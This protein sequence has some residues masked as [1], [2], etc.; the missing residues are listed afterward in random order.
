MEYYNGQKIIVHPRR[1][2]RSV[3]NVANQWNIS[4]LDAAELIN[5]VEYRQTYPEEEKE[6]IERKEEKEKEIFGLKPES[7]H[8]QAIYL[9]IELYLI[10]WLY[11]KMNYFIK[12]HSY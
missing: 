12:S 8:I 10:V 2:L 9:F 6:E 11:K 1:R 3:Y 7:I 5:N 4:P